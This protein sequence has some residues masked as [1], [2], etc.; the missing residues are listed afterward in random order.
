MQVDFGSYGFCEF[1]DIAFCYLQAIWD[2]HCQMWCDW[3]VE[4]QEVALHMKQFNVLSSIIEVIFH[5]FS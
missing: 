5:S 3:L 1:V 4:R 2:K